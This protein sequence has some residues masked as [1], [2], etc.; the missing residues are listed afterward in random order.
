MDAL[1]FNKAVSQHCEESSDKREM[2]KFELTA[3]SKIN[4]LGKKLFRIKAL[5]PFGNV[6][7]GDTGGWIEKEKNL[8][9]FGNAWVY[10]NAEVFDN[11]W[12]FGNAKVYGNA[13]GEH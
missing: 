5:I 6:R 11:A 2:K 7:E 4:I 8:S 3:E 13:K 9:H 1:Q 12:V 10:D